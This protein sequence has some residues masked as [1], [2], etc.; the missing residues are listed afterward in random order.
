M[1]SINAENNPDDPGSSLSDEATESDDG[2]LETS[3]RPSSRSRRQRTPRR[4][5]RRWIIGGSI[6]IVVVALAAAGGWVA[7][8][9]LQAQSSLEAAQTSV[10][11]VQTSLTSLD[12][13][14]LQKSAAAFAADAHDASVHTNDPLYRMAEML[15]I[16]G[17]NL[18]A[19]R[20]LSGSLD[21]LGS[22]A[23]M[24][25]ADFSANVTP[26]AL[27]PVNGKLNT[28]LLT[29]G[30][31]ALANADATI[32]AQQSTVAAINTSGTV[33]QIGAAQK[34]FVSALA[35]A[36]TEIT[37]VRSMVATVKN[38]LGM[39]GPR[40]Y[41]LAFLNNAETTALGGGPASLTMITVD[42]GAISITAQGSSQDFPTN[43]GAVR[44]VDQNLIN[45]YGTGIN[46]TLN[47]S[48]A[49]PDFPTAGQTIAAWWQKYKGT[50]VDGVIAID[51]IA[52]SYLL[53]ATGP[54]TLASGEQITADNAVALLLHDIYLR[55]PESQ[56]ESQT[57][58]FFADA[59]K[60]IFTGLTTTTADPAALLAAINKGIDS[61]NILAWSPVDDEEKL[62]GNSPLKGVLPTDNAKS[63]VIGT[64]FRDV[65]VSKTDFYLDTSTDLTTNVCQNSTAPTFTAT[66]TLHSTLTDAEAAAL[67]PFVSGAKF[68]GAKFSTEIFVYG[69]VG[70]SVVS[71]A[72]GDTSVDHSV[73]GNSEDL[74]RPVAHFGVDLAP[75]ETNTVTVTF[76]GASGTYGPPVMK[77]TPMINA[78]AQTMTAPG[79]G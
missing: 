57:D 56:I 79:C 73:Y 34:Q 61:G 40:H 76:S 8:Q 41:V 19:V 65:S 38:V 21:Q 28:D 23:L 55:Y 25:V 68:K 16:V 1:P 59:A 3:A 36:H 67:P 32:V 78:P 17:K 2:A 54:M 37:S 74:G 70:A 66:V 13:A 51:P 72:A 14:T 75:G 47:W 45:I 9:A 48:T 12:V 35:K 33:G 22:Q 77:V 71:T 46:S 52:L 4:R 63:T 64:Y 39:N 44:P 7:Y 69:P 49:R 5:R 24:P 6:A 42:N 58:I 18:T 26:A 11:E 10:T 15:P 29:A 62:L 20:E 43:D 30:D 27:R 31:T 50:S 53:G 60:T